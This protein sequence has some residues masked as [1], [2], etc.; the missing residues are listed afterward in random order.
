VIE[1]R[2]GHGVRGR[3]S[4]AC[5]SVDGGDTHPGIVVSK[6]REERVDGILGG[7]GGDGAQCLCSYLCGWIG[8]T[9]ERY[10]KGASRA[11][12][13]DAAECA[14]TNCGAW[15]A[16]GTDQCR[17]GLAVVVEQKGSCLRAYGRVAVGEQCPVGKRTR[18]CEHSKCFEANG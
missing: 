14:G 5:E 7:C 8:E 3:R 4:H 15:V 16:G 17:L 10:G 1:E 18:V 2:L 13:R 9:F 11:R 6:S 12:G